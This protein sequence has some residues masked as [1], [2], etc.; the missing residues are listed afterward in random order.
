M[1]LVRIP[2]ESVIYPSRCAC[3]MS[4][5]SG[6]LEIRKEDLKRLAMAALIA[7][8]YA[9]VGIRRTRATKVPYC[10]DCRNHARWTRLGGMHRRRTSGW[11]LSVVFGGHRRLRRTVLVGRRGSLE[12]RTI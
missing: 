1:K 11:S 9:A 10:A 8:R 7:T 2:G 6:T 3:C 12:G 5:S 4:P